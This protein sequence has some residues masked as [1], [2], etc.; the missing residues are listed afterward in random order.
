MVEKL[1]FRI[2]PT[3]VPFFTLS[4]TDPQAASDAYKRFVKRG[5]HLRR[6]TVATNIDLPLEEATSRLNVAIRKLHGL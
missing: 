1:E 2:H 6:V 3:A 5:L 4:Y